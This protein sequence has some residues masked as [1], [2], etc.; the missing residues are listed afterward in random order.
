MRGRLELRTADVEWFL[1]T[2]SADLGVTSQ[3]GRPSTF[4]SIIVDGREVEFSEG[5]SDLHTRVCEET[6]AGRGF[7]IDH[8]AVEP[9]QIGQRRRQV[10]R[11]ARRIE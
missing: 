9:G 1:S 11:D 6:L 8:G 4:R 10:V 3:T 7:A 5:F 2:D